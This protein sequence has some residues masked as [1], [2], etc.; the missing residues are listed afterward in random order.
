LPQQSVILD[1]RGDPVS[2]PSKPKKGRAIIIKAKDRKWT[3]SI[4]G[5]T[6]DGLWAA[7]VQ[8][9]SG[10]V[11]AL[12][13]IFEQAFLHDGRLYNLDQRRRGGVSGL[14]WQWRPYDEGMAYNPETG[15]L[16]PRE[17]DEKQKR[18]DIENCNLVS[19]VFSRIPGIQNHVHGF[20]GG[21][22]RGFAV[23]QIQWSEHDG[24]TRPFLEMVPQRKFTFAKRSDDDIITSYWPNVLTDDHPT[25][26]EELDPYRTIVATFNDA[27][28]PWRAGVMWPCIWYYLRKHYLLAQSMAIGE[29][30]AEPGII[31]Y[32][33][34]D[35]VNSPIFH[36]L[37]TAIENYGP[38]ARIV[39]TG[40]GG[41]LPVNGEE[42]VVNGGF[43]DVKQPDL[44]IPQGWTTASVQECDREIAIS[45]SGGNLI[46][47]TTG[48]TGTHAAERGQREGEKEDIRKPDADWCAMG[49]MLRMSQLILLFNKGPEAAKRPP[50]VDFPGL[51]EAEDLKYK[52][53]VL[54]L[55]SEMDIEKIRS[56]P[57]ELREYLELPEMSE[58]DQDDE[59]EPGPGDGE[60]QDEPG[61]PPGEDEDLE[62]QP[63]DEGQD[64]DQRVAS[65]MSSDRCGHF[66][67]AS[68]PPPGAEELKKSIAKILGKIDPY[69]TE[70]AE[71]V[72]DRVA[73]HLLRMHRPPKT[74]VSFQKN[75]IKLVDAEFGTYAKELQAAGLG[76]WFADTYKHYKTTDRS[77]WKKAPPPPMA[78]K[79]GLKDERMV[80]HMSKSANWHFSKMVNNKTFRDPMQSYL[81]R[82]YADEGAMLFDRNPKIVKAF[83]KTMGVEAKKLADYQIDRIARTSVARAREQARIMQMHDA[84]V[85]T[86]KV[87]VH[88]DACEVCQEYE[89]HIISVG[90]E[91]KWIDHLA[92]LEGDAWS[93]EMEKHSK[94]ALK[95]VPPHEFAAGAGGPLYHPNCRCETEMMFE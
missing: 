15:K 86:A 7:V 65:I 37:E 5:L 33:S 53:E 34:E 39:I 72:R 81:A 89:G 54:K 79:F 1:D 42:G 55:V 66:M 69:T 19:D 63:E 67:A 2:F 57:P 45:W 74:L 46:T 78:V 13:S 47:D 4:R 80:T 59:P 10:Q 32:T 26:G 31:G 40:T 60:D 21:T 87:V 35:D 9:D 77:L 18:E 75:L 51:Q 91:V 23:A 70:A 94:S 36:D 20:M 43:L 76:D 14:E 41:P 73:A 64:L 16:E 84:G 95:G 44:R 52:A 25:Y 12:Q 11:S 92:S 30:F 93:K 83:A 38:G 68:A 85:I 82:V 3:K 6:P 50:W 71:G 28:E 27:T 8:A 17:V 48:G 58:P 29:R 49:W 62:E 22:G 56:L 90:D 24:L 61:I 88:P